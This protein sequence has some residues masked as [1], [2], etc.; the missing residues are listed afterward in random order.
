VCASHSGALRATATIDAMSTTVAATL[1]DALEEVVARR[2]DEPAVRDLEG[3][4]S[5]TWRELRAA[6]ARFAGGLADLCVGRDDTVGLLL[7]NRPEFPVA[8]LGAV[9][10]GAVPVSI[11]ATSSPEQVAHVADDA[12]LRVLVVEAALAPVARAALQDRDTTLVVLD[13]TGEPLRDGEVA[14]ETVAAGVP[15]PCAAALEP[16]DLLTIIYTSGTTGPPKGVELTH[17]NLLTATRAIGELNAIG[18]GGRVICWLPM[19]HIAERIASY[20]APIVFGLQVTTCPDPRQIGRYLREVRPN[21][22]FAV[23]RVWEKLRAGAMAAGDGIPPAQLRAAL[24][25]DQVQAA[26]IGAA[27]SPPEL[28]DYFHGIG[29]PLAEIYGMSENCACCTCN[30]PGAIRAGTVGPPV[31]GTEIRIARAPTG[32]GS[33]PVVGEVLMRSDT[34]MRGYRGL[35]DATAEVIGDD[36]WL[37]T[38][39]VGT[40]DDDGYL[41]IVDRKKELII[42]AGGKNMSPSAIEAAIKTRSPLIGHVAVIGDARPYNVALIV[43]DPDVLAG[44]EPGDAAVRAE[45]EAAVD[46]GNATLSRAEQ[47]KRFEILE[48]PWMPGGEELTPTM[49]LRR[50]GIAARHGATIEALY[51]VQA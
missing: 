32:S 42:S 11:Y 36:G 3:S 24:G 44:R 2:G 34:I 20:Y 40:L 7:L 29:V 5:F 27:P 4:V 13:D 35:P 39:D 21:W 23:P 38:G 43:P 9:L 51:E 28:I 31:P 37:R 12:G 8:D 19:A 50:K 10:L 26:N 25:L 41:R 45:I 18:A 6:A 14:W 15:V 49:K 17:R 16:D 33:E 48:E 30:P 1:A 22:F 47:V 46:A